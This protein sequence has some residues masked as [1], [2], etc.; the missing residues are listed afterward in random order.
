MTDL[1]EAVRA[2]SSIELKAVHD[3]VADKL[4]DTFCELYALDDL[5][6][7]YAESP[8]THHTLRT[9]INALANAITDTLDECTER[10]PS[11][12]DATRALAVARRAMDDAT[13]TLSCYADGADGL[14]VPVSTASSMLRHLV[15]TTAQSIERAEIACGHTPTGGYLNNPELDAS[16]TDA[17]TAAVNAE[18]GDLS[19]MTRAFSELPPGQQK[20]IVATV[21]ELLVMNTEAI[22]S[23]PSTPAV[24]KEVHAAAAAASTDAADSA[25]PHLYR[26]HSLCKMLDA[27]AQ[28]KLGGEGLDVQNVSETIAALLTNAINV[29]D[30]EPVD[31]PLVHAPAQPKPEATLSEASRRA[32]EWTYNGRQHAEELFALLVK[33][34]DEVEL[35]E[36]MVDISDPKDELKAF[37]E[38]LQELIVESLRRDIGDATPAFC[39]LSPSQQKGL[40]DIAEELLVMNQEGAPAEEP[41][42]ARRPVTTVPLEAYDIATQRLGEISGMAALSA[43]SADVGGDESQVLYL[44]ARL[45]QEARDVLGNRLKEAGHD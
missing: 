3:F 8:F 15:L 41:S 31:T 10:L 44:I 26:A 11:D 37:G 24:D 23:V 16:A 25:K 17:G 28:E 22:T 43:A 32:A 19:E 33:D 5:A 27:F 9:A 14:L 45:A 20:T 7:R 42:G 12:H 36:S 35:G 21:K 2:E 34:P 40:V 30:G 6:R 13:E 38:R 4:G 18:S 1:S 29:L 39:K